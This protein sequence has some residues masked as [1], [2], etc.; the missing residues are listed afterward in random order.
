MALLIF[1]IDESIFNFLNFLIN[2]YSYEIFVEYMQYGIYWIMDALNWLIGS[3]WLVG[4]IP[5]YAHKL[6]SEKNVRSVWQIFTHPVW[7]S[8]Q[9][10]RVKQHIYH[11]HNI[12]GRNYLTRI[13]S[14]FFFTH[15]INTLAPISIMTLTSTWMGYIQLNSLCW[16]LM[17]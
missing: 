17:S 12:I 3:F 11:R 10:N 5:L 7:A 8:N 6:L 9:P 2:Q 4:S 16:R 1:S 15:V 13:P 14:K